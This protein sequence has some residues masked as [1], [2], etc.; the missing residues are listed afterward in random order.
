MRKIIEEKE[1]VVL[2]IWRAGE[3][4]IFDEFF[5]VQVIETDNNIKL[6]LTQNYSKKKNWKVKDIL[7]LFFIK[8]LIFNQSPLALPRGEKE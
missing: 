1:D 8:D 6:V 3:R 5:K 7:S 2:D 4:I